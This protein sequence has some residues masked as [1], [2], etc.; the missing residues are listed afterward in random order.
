[1]AFWNTTWTLRQNSRRL[2]NRENFFWSSCAKFMP[3]CV[4]QIQMIVSSPP[5]T[6]CWT[7]TLSSGQTW[8]HSWKTIVQTR[9]IRTIRAI[10]PWEKTSTATSEK[11]TSPCRP[12]LTTTSWRRRS[13]NWSMASS[14]QRPTDNSG[15]GRETQ[16]R[17]VRSRS[18]ER[19]APPL[20][21]IFASCA[22]PATFWRRCR[23]VA[24]PWRTASAHACACCWPCSRIFPRSSTWSTVG[25]SSRTSTL[26]RTRAPT[27]SP[28]CRSWSTYCPIE[29]RQTMK[30]INGWTGRLAT[31]HTSRPGT[32]WLRSWSS[33]RIRRTRLKTTPW[34]ARTICTYINKGGDL[35]TLALDVHHPCMYEH[36]DPQQTMDELLWTFRTRQQGNLPAVGH[37]QHTFFQVL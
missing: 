26:R 1:M 35:C 15:A 13:R 19:T 21:K 2:P 30:A 6:P 28:Q 24:P 16:P 27:R 32:S 8:P 29:A 34:W 5:V 17:N 4:T 10:A 20:S 23:A 22:T 25:S 14:A 7:P 36:R 12:T 3:R 37:A 31:W 33:Q 9:V 18:S 11:S